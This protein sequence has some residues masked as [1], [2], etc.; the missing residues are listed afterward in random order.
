MAEGWAKHLHA[1]RLDAYSGGTHPKGL[2]PRAVAVMSEAGVDI[3]GHSSDAIGDLPTNE[4]DLV[5]TVCSSAHEHCP[6]I[7]GAKRIEHHGFDDPPR[8]A[9]GVCDEEEALD[10]YRRVRDQIRAFVETLPERAGP[11]TSTRADR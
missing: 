5:I 10:H 6:T 4:F 3:S 8:M 1:D 9:E 7:D 11:A 2:D